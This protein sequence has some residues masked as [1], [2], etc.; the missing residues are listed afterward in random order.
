MDLVGGYALMYLGRACFE[1]TADR[2]NRGLRLVHHAICF[3]HFTHEADTP[4]DT[5]AVTCAVV[6]LPD[7][8]TTTPSFRPNW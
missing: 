1:Q 8:S 7:K 3:G 5:T 2:Q 6:A 4:A